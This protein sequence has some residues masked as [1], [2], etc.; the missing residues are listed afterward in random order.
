MSEDGGN[1]KAW[2]KIVNHVIGNG[3][4][5]EIP[6]LVDNGISYETVEE[7]AE[8]LKEMFAAKSNLE[9]EGKVPT[10]QENM[11]PK[12]LCKVKFRVSKVQRKLKSLKSG[13]ATGPDGIPARV[14]K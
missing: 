1:P 14:L 2:W 7:K 12:S 9:D 13:K 8:I 11:S 6:T 5:S 3:A 4:H 10:W